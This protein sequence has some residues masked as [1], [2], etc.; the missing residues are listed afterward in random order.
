[1]PAKISVQLLTHLQRSASRCWIVRLDEGYRHCRWLWYVR[2]KGFGTTRFRSRGAGEARLRAELIFALLYF[3]ASLADIND[4]TLNPT[5]LKPL[6]QQATGTRR[7]H[8]MALLRLSI[9]TPSAHNVSRRETPRKRNRCSSASAKPKL[10]TS[11]SLM[12][13]ARGAPR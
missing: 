13:A 2:R 8:G 10:Q 9:A 1:M 4:D 3:I 7:N 5:P 12:Q 6:P 11:E